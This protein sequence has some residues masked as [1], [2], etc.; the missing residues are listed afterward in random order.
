MPLVMVQYNPLEAGLNSGQR[1]VN[2][3]EIVANTKKAT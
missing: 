3:P 1:T 2:N